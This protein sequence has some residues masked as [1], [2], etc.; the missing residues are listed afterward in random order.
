VEQA[1]EQT[2]SLAAP[3]RPVAGGARPDPPAPPDRLTPREWEVA[4]LVACGRSN[5]EI[6]SALVI[7]EG[8]AIRHV[9][10]VLGKLG[11]RSRAGVA[12]WVAALPSGAGREGGAT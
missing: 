5:R 2:L 6:A 10:N 9:S 11:L 7:T 1:V 8:T 4:D 12:A 3:A